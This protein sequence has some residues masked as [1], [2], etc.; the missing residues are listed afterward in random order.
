MHLRH[1]IIVLGV[2]ALIGMYQTPDL[3][4]VLALP[5]E[6]PQLS[7]PSIIFPDHA[8]DDEL[9]KFF[10]PG[11]KN[12]ETRDFIQFQA[13][14]LILSFFAGWALRRLMSQF[15]GIILSFLGL[16]II[17][18][19]ILVYLGFMETVLNFGRLLD[20]APFLSFLVARIGVLPCIAFVLG[21]LVGSK[22]SPRPTRPQVQ[23]GY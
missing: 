22:R 6:Q 7:Q 9:L 20:V 3:R 5:P 12:R 15:K 16:F 19:F 1:L 21:F 8:S 23:G 4:N 10:V 18:L 14:T 11:D 13:S 2:L 17:F